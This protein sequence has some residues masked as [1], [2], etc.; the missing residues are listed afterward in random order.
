MVE[1]E[2]GLSACI[3]RGSLAGRSAAVRTVR[4]RQDARFQQAGRR[5]N[6]TAHA[7]FKKSVHQTFSPWTVWPKASSGFRHMQ[8]ISTASEFRTNRR[9]ST[10]LKK[11]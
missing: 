10:S 1:R 8:L 2:L 5:V 6:V 4:S 11:S 3:S 7:L 9:D